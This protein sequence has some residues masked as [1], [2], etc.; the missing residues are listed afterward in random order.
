MS[1]HFSLKP[2][3]RNILSF[4]SGVLFWLHFRIGDVAKT[5]LF[6]SFVGIFSDT[7]NIVFVII[8]KNLVNLLTGNLGIFEFSYI[9]IL[10]LTQSSI[11]LRCSACSVELLCLRADPIIHI[12]LHELIDLLIVDTLISKSLTR[13]SVLILLV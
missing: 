5:W 6:G 11:S 12:L 4:I 13:S 7:L 3:S 1:H 10:L 8:A 2:G 9:L